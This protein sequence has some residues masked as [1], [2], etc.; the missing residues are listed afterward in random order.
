[1]W[2]EM[3]RHAKRKGLPNYKKPSV[4]PRN[5]LL[6]SRV[7]LAAETESW[8]DSFIREVFRANFELDREISD[9]EVIRNILRRLSLDPELWISQAED[10]SVKIALRERT[11][12]AKAL[13]IF[14]APSFIAAGEL[15]WGDD[16]LEEACDYVVEKG[17]T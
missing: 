11:E 3:E 5:G 4:F 13:G 6:A 7:A 2:K 12:S 17:I 10:H 15:F 8:P 9:K 16:R 1:M 14:G